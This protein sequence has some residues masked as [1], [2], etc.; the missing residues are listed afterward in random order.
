MNDVRLIAFYLPQFHPIP[1]NDAWWGAGFT[2]WT[3]VTAAKPLFPGHY[4]P[5][6]PADLGFYDL[7]LPEAREA[8]ARLA[9]EHGIYGFC[10][11]YYYFNGKRLLHRPLDE[12]L[13]SG[14]PDFPFCL[15]WA[16]ENWSRRWDGHQDD[17]LIRQSHS[18]RDDKRFIGSILPAL[19]DPRYIRVGE[20]LLL[21]VYRPELLPDP[22]KTAEIWRQAVLKETG[23][24]LYICAVNNF[25]K[26]IDPRPLGYDATVQFPL[27]YTDRCKIDKSV[28]AA[29]HQMDP[30]S[31]SDNWLINFPSVVQHMVTIPK[32]GFTFFRGAFPSWDNTPRR[33]HASTVYLNSSPE[34]YKLY[35]KAVI[36]LTRKENRGDENLVFLNAWNEW[37][38]GAHLEPDKRYG[39][40]FLQA[41]REALAEE[42]DIIQTMK[43]IE[44]RDEESRAFYAAAEQ[45]QSQLSSTREEIDA[46]SGR[47]GA[48]NE[49]AAAKIEELT[50]NV[51]EKDRQILALVNQLNLLEQH[52]SDKEAHLQQKRDLIIEQEKR[53]GKKEDQILAKEAQL[54]EKEQLLQGKEGLLQEKDELLLAKGR[55]LADK[56]NSIQIKD[57][58]LIRFGEVIRQLEQQLQ[59]RDA[60]I[61]ELADRLQESGSTLS[62]LSAD[63]RFRDLELQRQIDTTAELT[64]R[65][66]R[67]NDVIRT[68]EEKV[69]GLASDLAAKEA[70]LA[71][72]EQLLAAVTEEKERMVAAMTSETD[73]LKQ[74]LEEAAAALKKS[75]DQAAGLQSEHTAA[76]ETIDLLE[77]RKD[78]LA[79]KSERQEAEI[80]RLASR[81]TALEQSLSWR[82]TRPLRLAIDGIFKLFYLLFPFGSRRWLVVKTLAGAVAHPVR[83]IRALH[84]GSWAAFMQRLKTPEREAQRQRAQAARAIPVS[85]VQAPRPAPGPASEGGLAF[86]DPPD[87]EIL[88]VFFQ[89]GELPLEEAARSVAA[90]ARRPMKF[91][92]T[93][94]PGFA[95]PPVPGIGTM[96]PK[97]IATL[98]DPASPIRNVILM[99][100]GVQ[101]LPGALE[102]CEE[103]LARR[104]D[105]AMVVPQVWKRDQML[106][107]AGVVIWEN[108]CTARIG[109][110]Q[111]PYDPEHL[112]LHEV[113]SGDRFVMVKKQIFRDWVGHALY[114]ADPWPFL[115]YDLSMATRWW[116]YKVIFQPRAHVLA[117]RSENFI[118]PEAR[119]V[120]YRKWQETLENHH[121]T[122][123]PGNLFV[124]RERGQRKTYMLMIDHYVPTFDKDAGSRSMKAYMDLFTDHGIVLKFIG[125][126]FYPIGCYVDYFQQRGV[127]ILYGDC[128]EKNWR[129]WL[130]TNGM[131]FGL[132]FISRPVVAIKY[133]GVVRELTRA[134]VLF[135][136]HDLHFLR[137][138]RKYLVEKDEELLKISERSKE[139]EK[140][141]IENVDAV[142]YPSQAE[143][144][145]VQK[146]FRLRGPARTI[147]LLIYETFHKPRYRPEERKGIMFVGGFMHEPNR[148]AVAW[149]LDDI[150]PLIDRQIPGLDLFIIG[151]HPPQEIRAR[152]GG[153]I[154]VTG[155]VD[156]DELMEYY[157]RCRLVIAPLRFGA[158]L[159]G[160]LVEAMYHGLPVITTSIGAEGLNG[161]GPAITVADTAEAFVEA[162]VN[163]YSAEDQ[164]KSRSEQAFEFVKENFSREKAWSIIQ[165]DLHPRANLGPG[166]PASPFKVLF[167][168][169]DAHLGGAQMLLISMLKWFQNHTS[170]DL[171]IMTNYGGRLLG[172]FHEIDETLVFNE[173]QH[174]HP[175][176]DDQVEEIL[177]FCEG[178]PDLVFGSS[179]AAGKSYHAIRHLGAPVISHIH[180]LKMS[181]GYYARD[182]VGDVTAHTA[183][184][185][186]GSRAVADNLVNDL[187]IKEDKIRVIHDFIEGKEIATPSATEK[188]RL[189]EQLGLEKEKFI[190]MACSA[191]L[192]W[193]KGA[194]L[195]VEIARHVKEIRPGSCHFY[196]IGPTDDTNVYPVYGSW[197][198]VFS[199]V[200]EYGLENELTFL[201]TRL[202]FKDYFA[203]SN[204]FLL[205]SREDPFPLVCLEAAQLGLPVICF[206]RSGGMPEFVEQDAGFVV[207]Y[208]DTLTAANRIVELHEN[209]ALC[210]TLGQ[211]AKHKV[212]ARHT[213]AIN[214]PRVLTCCRTIAGARPAV[215]VIVP[216]YNY[217]K[218]LEKRLESIVN[219]TFKD[220]EIILLDDASED[221][222]HRIIDRFSENHDV[223]IVRNKV[224]SGSVFK[225]WYQGIRKAKSD[226]VWIAESDDLSAETFLEKMLPLLNDPTVNLAWCASHVIDGD[227][228]LHEHFYHTTGY[229][230]GLPGGEKWK[231]PFVNSGNREV[232]DGLGIK[233]IIPNVSAVIMRRSALLE[234]SLEEVTSYRCAGDWYVYLNIIR[235]GNVAYLPEPLNFHRRHD[236]SVVGKSRN[237]AANTI[238]DYFR[239]HRFIDEHFDISEEAFGKQVDYVTK[240]LRGIWPDV[241]DAQY[242]ELYDP[243]QLK[244]IFAGRSSANRKSGKK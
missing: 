73:L 65:I 226:L 241:G 114:T 174:L 38:E 77:Q 127:E 121:M 97:E 192:F 191:G 78:E 62:R 183:F 120:F 67:Q 129:T 66:D 117:G 212:L 195:F 6:L 79:R 180:E 111:G 32:P 218:Y 194:D 28:F 95:G 16:N 156:D 5:H 197:D 193:R 64:G 160:K 113:D 48:E 69:S 182:F 37:A 102:A 161:A 43:E 7:R 12:M 235:T 229:Y 205:S 74:R 112:Y 103:T 55:Q 154:H 171:R 87:P 14:K 207:P 211:Q 92:V 206:D 140:Y 63:L 231:Q 135:Y 71:E 189:R 123:S 118:F 175:K 139:M 168:S 26:D 124:A 228:K 36:G 142:Y 39:L 84:G 105:W 132:A 163:V 131:H 239:I 244:K 50:R 108:G 202:D 208:E 209:R 96:T 217:G 230:A 158:G 237:T 169:H 155:Y 89:P 176:I 186:A 134:R 203:A 138:Y 68:L 45:L 99:H 30:A 86:P 128:C 60:R 199:K 242:K 33:D 51:S 34:L 23:S 49:R 210:H 107:S 40:R 85:P 110:N 236:G 20:R 18:A 173:L 164:L 152:A 130:K 75:E 82:L 151:S 44:E 166:K 53:V 88:V 22:A 219:Q 227:G 188:L 41:T 234:V 98:L 126:N 159:K 106:E 61:G 167:I 13:A 141:L 70:G 215:S 104:E 179:I 238:P 15:C 214:L 1:E 8:Q 27:D 146:E 2:E 148:D 91:V 10:Y 59:E 100:P 11:Y 223:T 190:V 137:E 3:N 42:T 177:K 80:R 25:I 145:I 101:V 216:N 72:M 187:K 162:V 24:D 184:Y 153:H 58:Q 204:V 213:V 115:A 144:E 149:L 81:Q 56:E 143:T 220:F 109:A 17:I 232:S 222:S 201:G 54:Q 200:R 31:L 133:L 76:L 170:V 136:G 185:I 150:C 94:N 52:I 4:Q 19:K 147:A 196:W 9:R 225:Q 116:G 119:E 224:N 83:F 198:T 178:K 29:L 125:D 240:E 122:S 181:I 93:G 21:L 233:N 90:N 165:P 243:A 47:L 57:N 35:L 172:R 157:R 221:D 46:L